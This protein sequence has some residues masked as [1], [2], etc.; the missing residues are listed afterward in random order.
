MLS[1]HQDY[2]GM[3]LWITHTCSWSLGCTMI[4]VPL[5]S[6][7]ESVV[8]VARTGR[9]CSK[10]SSLLSQDVKHPF[11]HQYYHHSPNWYSLLLKLVST[12]LTIWS[13]GHPTLFASKRLERLFV[14]DEGIV[15]DIFEEML[16]HTLLC[17]SGKYVLFNIECIILKS[18]RIRCSLK[19]AN[20][21][22]TLH[23]CTSLQMLKW[24]NVKSKFGHNL[25]LYKCQEQT[26]NYI[27]NQTKF[28]VRLII[29]IS[30]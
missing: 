16:D 19:S 20:A 1:R 25:N 9:K 3:L 6:W 12:Y 7:A 29:V 30:F 8:I 26:T 18:H 15:G 23:Q 17:A 22:Q 21:F 2:C 10:S 5:A 27:S 24:K 14:N 28:I 11:Y 4:N 13:K